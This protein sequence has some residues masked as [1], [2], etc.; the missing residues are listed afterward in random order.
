LTAPDSLRTA[1]TVA[2]ETPAWEATSFIVGRL[3]FIAPLALRREVAQYRVVE[4][5]RTMLNEFGRG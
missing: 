2:L 1:E 5:F 3:G 4:L